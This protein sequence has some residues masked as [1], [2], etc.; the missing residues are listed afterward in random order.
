GP[1]GDMARA[2]E[3]LHERTLN[4]QEAER[5]AMQNQ[6]T[7]KAMQAE[8]RDF[9]VYDFEAG[10][11]QSMSGAQ[12]D[13]RALQ[14]AARAMGESA[15]SSLVQAHS[16]IELSDA[17]TQGVAAVAHA[18]ERLAETVN[19]LNARMVGS[20]QA[21][22][23]AVE[24]VGNAGAYVDELAEATRR[25]EDVADLI[26]DIAD[27]T[28]MLALNATI[29]A[30][31]AGEAGKGFSV[32]AGEVKNLATQTA[33]ATD[34]ITRHIAAIRAA[35]DKA[36][37]SMD[38]VNEAI[39]DMNAIARDVQR[40]GDEQN[41]AISEISVNARETADATRQS[42]EYIRQVGDAIEQTGFTAHEMLASVDDLAR[43]MKKLE[44]RAEHF[45]AT[46]REAT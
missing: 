12:K 30:A 33:K 19:A 26:V 28:N 38:G 20:S 41:A 6:A 46:L 11:N 36:R 1:F 2:V 42:L 37:G 43:R 21:V 31:R 44:D 3:A 24:R 7:H 4:R 22:V 23:R 32:V 13:T 35:V 8:E 25:I 16:A 5:E 29:E 40:A 18:A 17:A 39:G 14:D 45:V 9:L 34:D 15:E 27:Q 10:V